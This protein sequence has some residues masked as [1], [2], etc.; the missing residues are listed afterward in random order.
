MGPRAPV[1]RRSLAD[2]LVWSNLPLA[3]PVAIY[4]WC[5]HYVVGLS[6]LASCTASFLYHRSA[7]SAFI[8]VDQWCATVAFF[9]TLALTTGMT[10][11][12]NAVLAVS[13]GTAFACYLH[14][15]QF[16]EKEPRRYTAWHT[17]WH[18]LV[19]AG[20]LQVASSLLR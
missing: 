5:G 11:L 16:R 7:E 14:A 8:T 19:C 1:D 13:V 17:A 2:P 20:Q 4:L 18:L 12:A 6:V 15:V 3:V 9:A 10:L